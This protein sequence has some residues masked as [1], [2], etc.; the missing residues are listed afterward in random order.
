MADFNKSVQDVI[1]ALDGA[2][3]NVMAVGLILI[4][5]DRSV[6]TMFAQDNWASAFQL[7]GA[8]EHLKSRI[9][10]HIVSEQENE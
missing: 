3:N 10:F 9:H 4:K 2:R 8:A 1:D 5:R 7:M 6:E